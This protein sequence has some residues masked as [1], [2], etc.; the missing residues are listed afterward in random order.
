MFTQ[1]LMYKRISKHPTALTQYAEKL[2]AEGTVTKQEY[3]V[4]GREIFVKYFTVLQS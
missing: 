3:E 4:N 1:P 2:I